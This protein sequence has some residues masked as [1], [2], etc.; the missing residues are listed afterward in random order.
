MNSNGRSADPARSA[1]DGLQDVVGDGRG[2]L[3][4]LGVDGGSL[5][6]GGEHDEPQDAAHDGVDDQVGGC[7][8]GAFAA[9]E[10]GPDDG[11]AGGGAWLDDGSDQVVPG[12]GLPSG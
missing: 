9:V 2:V 5:G 12:R 4:P 8:G 7:A 6:A 10:G 3:V 11:L 1:A